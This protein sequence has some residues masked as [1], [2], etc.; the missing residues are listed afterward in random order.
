MATD[1]LNLLLLSRVCSD[2]IEPYMFQNPLN[3]RSLN[4]SGPK[5]FLKWT[6]EMLDMSSF[7]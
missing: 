5:E 4:P 2:D 7:R 1:D 3:E 6:E